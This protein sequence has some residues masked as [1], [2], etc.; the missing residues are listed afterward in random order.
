[1]DLLVSYSWGRF[2]LARDEIVRI[3]RRFGDT[4]PEVKKSAVMGIAIVHTCLDNREVIRRCHELYESEAVFEFAIK[5]VPVDYW[6]QTDLDAI[7][8]VIKDH[9]SNRI[10]GNETW[11]MTVKKRRWQ[12]YHT[13]DIVEYLAESIDSK[14]DLRHPDWIVWVDVVG[15]E[16]AISLLKPEDI[17]SLGL[18]G[19]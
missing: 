13:I 3:L 10:A 1:M 17:F 18:L 4:R 9:I 5:W 8:Q 19:F 15:N 14:V 12:E 16:T 2:F 11:G 7:N 6:S